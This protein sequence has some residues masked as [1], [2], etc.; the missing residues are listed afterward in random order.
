MANMILKK[1]IRTQLAYLQEY[2]IMTIN[3]EDEFGQE[4]ELL[5]QMGER[6]EQS[7]ESAYSGL[8]YGLTTGETFL[9]NGLLLDEDG[10]PIESN[11]F[12][13][14]DWENIP[15]INT[16]EEDWDSDV[17]RQLGDLTQALKYVESDE[18]LSDFDE[19][20]RC[21]SINQY[22]IDSNQYKFV[23]GSENWNTNGEEEATLLKNYRDE[24]NYGELLK[25]LGYFLKRYN[26]FSKVAKWSTQEMNG[27]EID[28]ANDMIEMGYDI[29]T[30]EEKEAKIYA[31]KLGFDGLSHLTENYL[32]QFYDTIDHKRIYIGL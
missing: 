21:L 10:N 28:L 13:R 15:C 22:L 25:E 26:G 17:A 6:Y 23:Y 19:I 1:S 11:L 3:S 2:P 31:V 29:S 4:G 9:K 27:M 8:G 14:I 20:Y 12:Y 32:S 5:A 30:L 7:I 16:L 18:L 24:K